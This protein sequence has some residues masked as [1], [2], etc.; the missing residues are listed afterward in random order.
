MSCFGEKYGP[1]AHGPEGTV[2]R[3]TFTLAG[4]EHACIDSPLVHAFF[5]CQAIATFENAGF[6]L[7]T[8][9]IVDDAPPSGPEM[10]VHW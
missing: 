4:R 8:S 9:G 1:N 6:L 2:K 7:S 3:A 5:M 10:M